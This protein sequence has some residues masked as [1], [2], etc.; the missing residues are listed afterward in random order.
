MNK[1]ISTFF[2]GYLSFKYR[3]LLRTPI[4]LFCFT[5]LVVGLYEGLE[6]SGP[7][8][9]LIRD[10]YNKYSFYQGMNGKYYTF[11]ES[12]Q[13]WGDSVDSY[14]EDGTLKVV[15]MSF[16][17]FI[18]SLKSRDDLYPSLVNSLNDDNYFN[19]S[20][21]IDSDDLKYYKFKLIDLS[22]RFRLFIEN[23]IIV[24]FV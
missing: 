15:N 6:K 16:D 19:Q 17:V 1:L 2:F 8:Y 9:S 22:V 20:W 11:Q 12:K 14:L 4:I 21:K 13:L 5:L 3:R 23:L 18:K 24:L 10:I 7:D